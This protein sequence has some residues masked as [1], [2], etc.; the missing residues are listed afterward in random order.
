MIDTHRWVIKASPRTSWANGMITVTS[1]HLLRRS[2]SRKHR[3]V[4]KSVSSLPKLSFPCFSVPTEVVVQVYDSTPT[5]LSPLYP[6]QAS[7]WTLKTQP[8]SSTVC[9]DSLLPSAAST[10]FLLP[11]KTTFGTTASWSPKT[12]TGKL[13]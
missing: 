2:T 11:T 7:R 9:L 1:L 4:T 5:L 6:A 3:Y 12:P 8:C 10:Y 13:K